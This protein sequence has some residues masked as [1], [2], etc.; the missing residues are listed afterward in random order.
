MTDLR[1]HLHA[2][3]PPA[4]LAELAQSS[5]G[6]FFHTPAWLRAVR[7]AAPHLQPR[8]IA[9]EDSAGTLRAALPLLVAERWG[10]RR[11]Y[12]GAWGT[13]G[14]VVAHDPAAAA[15]AGRAL[16]ALARAPRTALVR[17]HDFAAS[18]AS[19]AGWFETEE[20]CLVLDLPADPEVLFRDAFTTQNRNK[21]RKAEKL[22]VAVRR[23][24][25]AE[26]LG[27]YADLYAESAL[28]WQLATPLPRAFFLALAAAPAGVD[29]W[30]AE[31]QGQVM[32]G[33]LN[34]TCGGQ[35]MNWGNVSRRDAWGA[36]PNNLLHWRALAAACAD[37][38]GPRLYNFGGS[39]GLPGV[40]TF[41]SAFGPRAYRYRRCE[42]RAAWAE[43]LL[44]ARRGTREA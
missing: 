36:S 44:R 17:V 7:V 20:V 30:L 8:V 27:L 34:F 11:V 2:G 25:G 23:G 43:W 19:E 14:G 32:A 39:T 22:G 10:V 3:E 42:H 29:V 18:L 9:V 21:I 4:A 24:A 5:A 38:Y 33:L 37:P 1:V 28:R 40:E 16:A 15:A 41:K 26:A 12:A 13:Y 35:I 31:H 6:S